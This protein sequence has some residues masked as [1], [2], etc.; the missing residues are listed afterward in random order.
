MYT[1]THMHPH[2]SNSISNTEVNLHS[3][4]PKSSRGMLQP[5]EFS[6]AS[7]L[8]FGESQHPYVKALCNLHWTATRRSYWSRLPADPVT[9]LSPSGDFTAASVHCLGA[10]PHSWQSPISYRGLPRLPVQPGIT[11]GLVRMSFQLHASYV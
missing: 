5:P 11:H 8:T 9:S 7:Q 2:T 6:S 4:C 3:V 10:Y 1:H